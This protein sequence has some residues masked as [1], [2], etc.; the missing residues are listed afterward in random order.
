VHSTDDLADFERFYAAEAKALIRSVALATGRPAMAEDAVAEA[1]ARAWLRWPD[2]RRDKR[3]PAGWI[4]HVAL[5]E[6]RGRFRRLRT[7]RRKAHVVARPDSATD[8]EPPA[9]HVWAAVA[10]LSERERSLIALRYLADLTQ[11]EIAQALGLPAGTVASGLSRARRRL[12][13]TL[14]ATFEETNHG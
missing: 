10:R 8:P 11:D 13:V 12:G 2:L 1:F 5:N 3:S 14:G 4:M 6:C 9:A 7:E